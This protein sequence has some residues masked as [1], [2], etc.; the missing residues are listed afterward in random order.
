MPRYTP[1]DY[2][3]QQLMSISLENQICPGTME[4]VIHHLVEKEL[5][6]SGIETSYKNDDT[7]RPALDPRILFKIILL[8]Y[9]KG[10]IGSRKIEQA[11]KENI[12]F[13]ALSCCQTPDHSTIATFV[14]VMT[15]QIM[16]PCSNK[17]Y[18]SV[19]VRVYSVEPI[20]L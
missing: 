6:F 13:M 20:S 11:C 12:L 3:Q 17:Y 10:I 18:W 1:Y 7:G 4:Y 14:T 15:D 19:I 8:A 2:R 16:P 9:S 5:D